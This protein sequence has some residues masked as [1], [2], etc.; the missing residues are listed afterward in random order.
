MS[1]LDPRAGALQDALAAEHAAVWVLGLLLARTSASG[2]PVLAA[3]LSASLGA[4]RAQRDLLTAQ[5]RDLGEEPVA[6]AASYDV[7]SAP[8]SRGEVIA[9]AV[10]TE[11]RVAAAW[12]ALV[13]ALPAGERGP[14]RRALADAAVRG[15]VVRGSP[16]IF[17]GADELADR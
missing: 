15:L 5:V 2:D 10:R 13:A 8:R 9:L 14:A 4:H 6:A 16:E 11:E 3:E 1:A 12:A 17:P 7:G